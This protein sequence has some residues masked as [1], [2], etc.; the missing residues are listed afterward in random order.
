M[1][2]SQ[3]RLLTNWGNV[4]SIKSGYNRRRLLLRL[5]GFRY[6]IEIFVPAPQRTYGYLR[7]EVLSGLT[8]AVVLLLLGVS[9]LVFWMPEEADR[10]SIDGKFSDWSGVA[11]IPD[12][13]ADQQSNRNVNLVGGALQADAVYL[14]IYVETEE[15]LFSGATTDLLRVFIDSDADSATGYDYRGIGADHLLE[16][17]GASTIVSAAYL[18]TWDDDRGRTDWNGFTALTSVNARTSASRLETQVPLFD[19]GLAEGE[20]VIALLQLSDSAGHEDTFD[21]VL[22]AGAA[23][24]DVALLPTGDFPL[25]EGWSSPGVLRLQASRETSIDRI[26]FELEGTH[27]ASA[28]AGVELVLPDGTDWPCQRAGSQLLCSG[29]GLVLPPGTAVEL[30]VRVEIS[31]AAE[32]GTTLQLVLGD[33]L[34]PL[35]SL[36][37]AV[38]LF[39]GALELDLALVVRQMYSSGQVGVRIGLAR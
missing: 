25:P 16:I 1:P 13:E 29:A 39:E 34:F 4:V 10:V 32:V 35:V 12:S 2:S 19:L 6:R 20:P 14:S 3:S 9:F 31:A 11:I 23:A 33:L 17:A 21:T 37:V 7:M 5:F 8:N 30:A 18:Y 28:I 38:I 36:A 22:V 24:L 26:T 27:A 15:S